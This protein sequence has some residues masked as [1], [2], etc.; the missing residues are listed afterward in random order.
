MRKKRILQILF[1]I[2]AFYFL[3]T[4]LLFAVETL[5]RN[6][7]GSTIT[8]LGDAAWYLLATLTTVG[9]G[10]ITPVTF[11]GKMIGA[12]MM[13]SSAGVLTFVLGLLFS[14]LFGKLLPSVRLWCMRNRAWYVFST[15]DEHTQILAMHLAKTDPQAAY[16]FCGKEEAISQE[17][18]PAMRHHVILDEPLEVLI[19]RQNGEKDCSV[20]FLTDK[21]WEN[22]NLGCGLLERAKCAK[23]H[24]YCEADHAPDHVPAGMV[25]FHRADSIARIYW[26]QSPI[27]KGER[28]VLLVGA[29]KIA[30]S[31]LERGLLI[32]VL[33]EE[34]EVAYHVFG[35][36][37]AFCADH[38]ELLKLDALGVYFESEDWNADPKLLANASRIIFCGD[39]EA[40]NL[41]NMARLRRYFPTSAR[42]DVYAAAS[43]E[44]CNDFGGDDQLLTRE[45]VMQERLNHTAMLLNDLYCQKTGGGSNW[46]ELSEFH[47]Q[48]NIAAADHMLTKIRLLLPQEDCT[49]ITKENC[50]MAYAKYRALDAQGKEACRKL[51][52]E[53]WVRFHVMNNWRKASERDNERRL[54]PMLV[55]YEELTKE[56]QALDDSAWEVLGEM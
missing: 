48:S 53:R 32:N 17:H 44:R 33:P 36:W 46:T 7:Q 27:R 20:F 31:L 52:H 22:Y 4:I 26:T 24:V 2:F 55:R 6:G 45:V 51:E 10:D 5:P 14:M 41:E 30:R 3:L 49:Q 9:Y 40:E 43:D 56:E 15:L 8:S 13:I 11:A 16:I 12:V 25:L 1:S 47:R 50:A 37:R 54:H 19:G 39:D 35:D 38:Y 23:L 42:V 29:G 18:Y 28:T 34:R 21:A